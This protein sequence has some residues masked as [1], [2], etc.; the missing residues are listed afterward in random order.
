ML[1]FRDFGNADEIHDLGDLG[2][3]VVGGRL[4]VRQDGF[5]HRPALAGGHDMLAQGFGGLIHLHHGVGRT[6]GAGG[7][8]ACRDGG[9]VAAGH[10]CLGRLAGEFVDHAISHPAMGIPAHGVAERGH[11]EGVKGQR[12]IEIVVIA[13]GGMERFGAAHL[14]GGFSE[15]F[16]ATWDVMGLHRGLG[17]KK[18]AQCAHA[19]GRMGIGMATG[20]GAEAGAGHLARLGGLAI[21]GNAV[22]FR[23]AADGRP[24]AP[25]PILPCGAKGGGHSGRAFLDGKPLAAQEV[26][27]I[28]RALVFA[29]GGF[30][31]I[32]DVAGPARQLGHPGC[33]GIAGG[34][35]WVLHGRA[36]LLRGG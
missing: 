5:I 35:A 21:A 4:S 24:V 11:V 33:N 17:G 30:A 8:V 36:L 19:E 22:I 9:G 3:D 34:L 7:G 25:V 14:F 1:G 29:P 23:I 12:G 20:V 6:G 10:P 32:P 27:V 13:R 16:Q 26:D 31:E 28:G 2:G 15:E 18:A